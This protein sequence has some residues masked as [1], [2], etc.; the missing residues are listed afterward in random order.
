MRPCSTWEAGTSPGCTRAETKK[1]GLASNCLGGD[2]VQDWVRDRARGTGYP[3]ERWEFGW[4][5]KRNKGTGCAQEGV[6]VTQQLE[7]SHLDLLASMDLPGQQA[8]I[9]R[10]FL[11]GQCL[12]CGGWDG[13]LP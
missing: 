9:N 8:K 12:H 10:F 13:T 11:G 1:T 6:R 7:P 3:A 2:G 4:A 5:K